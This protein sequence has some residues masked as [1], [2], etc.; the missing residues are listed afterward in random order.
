MIGTNNFA[1]NIF[2]AQCEIVQNI[3][4]ICKVRACRISL[5]ISIFQELS[6][7]V[8]KNFLWRVEQII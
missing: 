3:H 4:Y 8:E 1:K 5:K 7:I 2:K 6:K